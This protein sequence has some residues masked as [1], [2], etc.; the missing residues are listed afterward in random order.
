MSTV[1]FL[2]HRGAQ[3]VSEKFD[4]KTKKTF[5]T[6]LVGKISTSRIMVIRNLGLITSRIGVPKLP[7]MPKSFKSVSTFS[8]T[9]FDKYDMLREQLSLH[10]YNVINVVGAEQ[11][12]LTPLLPS[13]PKYCFS[14]LRLDNISSEIR[15][16]TQYAPETYSVEVRDITQSRH[17]EVNSLTIALDVL[18]AFPSRDDADDLMTLRVAIIALLVASQDVYF[19]IDVRGVTS[20]PSQITIPANK[21]GAFLGVIEKIAKQHDRK[22]RMLSREK[23]GD[24]LHFLLLA[25]KRV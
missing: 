5:L 9:A 10:S 6:L 24:S 18:T 20:D 22:V 1:V 8:G 7:K 16:I 23:S 15:A 3:V 11:C 2:A 4:K 19:N 14:N 21:V 13:G 12:Y 17:Y 25:K